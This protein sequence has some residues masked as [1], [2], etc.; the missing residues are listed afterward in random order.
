MAEYVGQG[1]LHL[2]LRPKRG[3]YLF[4]TGSRAQFCAAVTRASSR[5]GGLQEPIV[6]VSPAG[7]IQPAWEQIVQVLAPTW[8]LI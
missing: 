1:V 8:S 2:D 5:W 4:R 3:A 6:P 7:R